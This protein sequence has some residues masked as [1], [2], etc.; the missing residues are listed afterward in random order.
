MAAKEVAV[1]AAVTI[2]SGRLLSVHSQ[3]TAIALVIFFFGF[4][5]KFVVYFLLYL[6]LFC[7]A[8][9]WSICAN[10]I[11]LY[12]LSFIANW[13]MMIKCVNLIANCWWIHCCLM[14]VK[15]VCLYICI[16][17]KKWQSEFIN[18]SG[19]R[20]YWR[21]FVHRYILPYIHSDC[22]SDFVIIV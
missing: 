10:E 21:M 1:A 17:D 11:L 16:I 6:F 18:Q 14:R 9:L 20:Y 22:F 5:F 2:A 8:R 3:S 4:G 15:V 19:T 7:F 13:M 12:W